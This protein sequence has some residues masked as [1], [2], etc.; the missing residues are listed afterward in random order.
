MR[1]KPAIFQNLDLP[2]GQ[3]RWVEYAN[4]HNPD[5]TQIA[6]EWH[7]WM[8]H[9]YDETPNEY[10]FSKNPAIAQASDAVA[11]T[12]THLYTP[13]YDPQVIDGK[14]QEQHNLSQYRYDST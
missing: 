10:K 3:H 4:I 6:P 9:V 13:P 12:T 11:A 7:G 1:F 2:F 14:L 5:P 8:H